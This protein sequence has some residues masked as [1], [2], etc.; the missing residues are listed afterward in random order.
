MEG[1]LS[2]ESLSGDDRAL[3][4]FGLAAVLDQRGLH[5]RAAAVLEAAN[6]HQ[7]GANFAQDSALIPTSIPRLSTR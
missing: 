4:H 7:S 6:L 3:L 1:L 2:D 5:A